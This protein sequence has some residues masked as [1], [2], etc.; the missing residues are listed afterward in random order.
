[1]E[2]AKKGTLGGYKVVQ[3]AKDATHK[4][5]TIQEDKDL[6][7]HIYGLQIELSMEKS[8]RQMD[9]ETEKAESA[10]AIERIKKEYDEAIDKW[11][12][13][14]EGLKQQLDYEK[15]LNENLRRISRER[16]NADRK[17]KPKTEH[18]GYVVLSS[19]EIRYKY[20]SGTKYLS[21]I[22]WETVLEMPYPVD[23]TL[24]QVEHEMQALFRNDDTGDWPIEKIGISAHYRK[25]FEQLIHDPEWTDWEEYNVLLDTALRA[26]YKSGY[27]EMIFH[28][29]KPLG[30]VPR[31]MRPGK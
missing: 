18:T 27:W 23:F 31:D 1:M 26:N 13:Y 2:Y 4:V 21:T 20:R 25:P 19:K 3:D 12:Q 28:H 11:R 17:L 30:I 29:T 7:A 24:Q 8:A 9:V 10:A 22:L 6:E 15:G 5:R 16:A 14:A